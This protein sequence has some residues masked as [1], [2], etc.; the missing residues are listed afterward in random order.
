MNCNAGRIILISSD[1]G[2]LQLV[3]LDFVHRAVF[4]TEGNVLQVGSGG[5]VKS[6]YSTGS[7]RKS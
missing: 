6:P 1:D 3:F 4:P 7:A 2:I 5:R